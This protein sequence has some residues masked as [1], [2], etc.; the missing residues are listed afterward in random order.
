MAVGGN[1]TGRLAVILVLPIQPRLEFEIE[2]VKVMHNLSP[3]DTK[4]LC[5]LVL[6]WCKYDF[7]KT[8][9]CLQPTAKSTIVVGMHLAEAIGLL[10]SK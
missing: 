4:C 9:Y 3:V 7:E 6:H 10:P 8:I 5:W 1:N 2:T